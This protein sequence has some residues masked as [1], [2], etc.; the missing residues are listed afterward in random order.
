MNVL[1]TPIGNY[2]DYIG[3]KETLESLQIEEKFWQEGSLGQSF[4]NM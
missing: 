3:H 1:S 2:K 4:F